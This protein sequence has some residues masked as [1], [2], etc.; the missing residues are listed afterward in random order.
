MNQPSRSPVIYLRAYYF[1]T[2]RLL[3]S[4]QHPVRYSSAFSSLAVL[5]SGSVVGLSNCRPRCPGYTRFTV[6]SPNACRVL[7]ERV[8]WRRRSYHS[9][10]IGLSFHPLKFR[11]S[12]VLLTLKST[13]QIYLFLIG[14]MRIPDE[15]YGMVWLPACP[16]SVYIR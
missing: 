7:V 5:F 9:E 6:L 15:S 2:C 8:E 14:R 12:T 16:F 1:I 11:D 13:N 3:A 4:R 10:Q